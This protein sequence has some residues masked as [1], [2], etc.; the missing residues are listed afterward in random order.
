MSK[1]S[2]KIWIRVSSQTAD[3][4]KDMA[5]AENCSPGR[6]VDKLVRAWALSRKGKE[7]IYDK[8]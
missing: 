8:K 2:V 1:R 4:L 6:I 5:A 7:T 3:H